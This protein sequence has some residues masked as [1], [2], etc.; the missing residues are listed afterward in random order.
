[1]VGRVGCGSG[2]NSQLIVAPM[3]IAVVDRISIGRV[4]LG[5]SSWVLCRGVKAEGDHRRDMV[6]RRE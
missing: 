4:R 2:G 3:K 6:R 5:S 1:M